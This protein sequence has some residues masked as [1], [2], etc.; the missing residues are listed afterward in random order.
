IDLIEELARLAG[1]DKVP[2]KTAPSQIMDRH[3]YTLRQKLTDYFVSRAFFETLTYSWDDPALMLRLGFNDI[4]PILQMPR[5]KNPQD[6]NQSVMR[7]SLLPSLLSRML[8]NLNYGER[9]IR[10][11][12]LSKVYRVVD[13]SNCE[14]YNLTAVLSGIASGEHWMSKTEALKL[15]HVKGM[16][17]QMLDL[18]GIGGIKTGE[19]QA[20]FYMPGSGFNYSNGQGELASFG[21]LRPDIAEAFGIDTITLKQDVW[22][23][24][25]EVQ[26]LTE[27]T[28]NLPMVFSPISR[29]PHVMRDISFLLKKEHSYRKLEETILA[30]ES[31]II[32]SVSV[33][34]EYR[35]DKLPEGFRSVSLHLQL[36]D[37]QKTLTEERIEELVD[38]VIKKLQSDLDIIMR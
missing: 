15:F 14:H 9:N 25:I 12:E 13:G 11:F 35:S 3:A 28:R 37:Q 20:P 16:V 31:D 17:E 2:Q 23:I 24:Q 6:S 18:L 10:L 19:L 8:Y 4:D 34:D 32:E 38:F 5:I 27:A 26:N 33:F 21:R 36:R 1:Y 7:S 22:I 30:L 29:F